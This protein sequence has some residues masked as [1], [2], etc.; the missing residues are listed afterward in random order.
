[1]KADLGFYIAGGLLLLAC[2]LKLPALVRARGQDWLLSSICALLLVGAGVLF[3]SAPQ[4]IIVV[5]RAT[6]VSNFS[7]PV[8]YCALTGFSAASVVLV[9]NWRG[10]L[11]KD[12]TRRLSQ[13]II[14][15]YLLVW[16]L[17][18]SLYVLGD[19]PVERR[20]DFDVYYAETP[21]IR[22]MILLYLL[23]HGV[24]SFFCSRL[25]WRWSRD[26]HGT[27]RIGLRALA[28][29]YL[30]H[31][32]GYDAVKLVAIGAR[33][34]GHNWDF[35]AVDVA[36]NMGQPSALLVAVG[37]ILPLVGRRSEE[38]IRYWQLAQLA[39]TVG[40]VQGAPSPDMLALPWWKPQLRLR[41][42]QRQTYISDRLV[43]C[44]SHFSGRIWSEAHSAAVARGAAE[45]A[46]NVIAEAAMIA[47]AVDT[48]N[49]AG[50]ESPAG[51]VPTDRQSPPSTTSDLAQLSRALRTRVVKDVRRR[52]RALLESTSA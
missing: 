49:A 6:G 28:L 8:V 20:T 38:T 42:T 5:N 43:V 52:H 19:A 29:G 2:L 45:K 4:T 14:A 7:G 13:R 51:H 34:S 10:S 47:A 39:R 23:A 9:L 27:M 31:Y 3:T 44:R 18:I 24:A 26:V 37:F 1:M 15:V 35:L 25:C 50:G 30:M 21:Y 17:I 11:D 32:A 12:R 16:A 36:P 48:H 40:R 22:E 41:L 46:A 33:W